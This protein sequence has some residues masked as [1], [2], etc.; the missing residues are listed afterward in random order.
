[1]NFPDTG[2]S[3]SSISA[4]NIGSSLNGVAGLATGFYRGNWS[5]LFTALRTNSQN[6]I[7]ATPSIVT[8]D[9]MEAEFSVGQEVPI[10]TGS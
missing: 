7:L 4:N 8:L 9:N 3:A 2:A 5:G 6:D 1:S 10:L